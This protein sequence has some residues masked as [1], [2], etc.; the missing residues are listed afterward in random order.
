MAATRARSRRE[1]TGLRAGTKRDRCRCY[2]ALPTQVFIDGRSI[3]GFDDMQV[4]R[5]SG[6]LFGLLSAAGVES[7]GDKMT[8]EQLLAARRAMVPAPQLEPSL[9]ARGVLIAHEGG[10]LP[11]CLE[12]MCVRCTR[13]P[14]S[15]FWGGGVLSG[16]L[17]AACCC[18]G[19][20][21]R[22]RL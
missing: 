7:K 21:D 15:L 4:A 9:L 13:A 8:E 5:E 16:T 17:G 14:P 3:G 12:N 18:S 6:A 11:D 20:L 19:P 2:C 22:A 1:S 10:I